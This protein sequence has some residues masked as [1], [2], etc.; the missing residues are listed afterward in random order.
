MKDNLVQMRRPHKKYGEDVYFILQVRF[1]NS[2][3][4][5]LEF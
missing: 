1:K 5:Y 4:Q 2:I 3:M